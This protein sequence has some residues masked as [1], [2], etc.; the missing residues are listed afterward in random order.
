MD[1][2]KITNKALTEE[3]EIK[4]ERYTKIPYDIKNNKKGKCMHVIHIRCWFLS[5]THVWNRRK[6]N[7]QNIF[8]WYLKYKET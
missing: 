4:Y 7:N 2:I 1:I 3:L 8:R 5:G 6:H